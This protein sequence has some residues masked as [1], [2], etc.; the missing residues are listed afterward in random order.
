MLVEREHEVAIQ[1]L[2]AAAVKHSRLLGDF[3][4]QVYTTRQRQRQRQLDPALG[5]TDCPDFLAECAHQDPGILTCSTSTRAKLR[6][7][8][9]RTLGTNGPVAVGSLNFPFGL[10][11]CQCAPK[12]N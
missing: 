1:L 5:T 2:L 10:F 11:R 12:E 9:I 7:V 3:M 6:E 8:I 4:R